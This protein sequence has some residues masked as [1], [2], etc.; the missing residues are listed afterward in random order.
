LNERAYEFSNIK[1][2]SDDKWKK[3]NVKIDI[4]KTLK[5]EIKPFTHWLRLN[6]DECDINEDSISDG[7]SPCEANDTDI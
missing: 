3:M 5:R 1:T 6:G 4:Y 7:A 2:I